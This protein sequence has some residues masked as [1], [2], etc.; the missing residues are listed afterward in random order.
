MGN[1]KDT[2]PD[3]L[4]EDGSVTDLATPLASIIG[5]LAAERLTKYLKLTTVGE[6]LQH[7]PRRYL[8]PKELTPVESLV[9]GEKVSVVARVTSI[10]SRAMR[11]R[12][13][14]ITTVEIWDGTA[15]LSG[16]ME[17]T[18]FYKWRI[19]EELSVGSTA[20]FNGT[21]KA[22][23]GRKSL[24]NP[25][26]SV[27]APDEGLRGDEGIA[28]V[29]GAKMPIPIY[30]VS[31]KLE[32]WE[33]KR[34]AQTVLQ[35]VNLEALPDPLPA[36][37][38]ER[39][40]FGPLAEA[41]RGIHR[42]WD[43][44]DWKRARAH[45]RYAEAL[46]MQT[47]LARRRAIAASQRATARPG[48]PD[49]LLTRFDAS[50]PFDLTT[51]QREVGATIADGVA[52]DRAMNRLLQG[53]VGSGKTVVALRAMLQVIDS[54]GQ[55]ALLAP[56][57]VLAA[58]HYESIRAILG[59]LAEGGMLGG[60]EDGTRVTLLTG[61][62]PTSAKKK[63]LLEAASGDAGIVVGT[64]A[65]L[66]EHVQFFDLGLIVVDEQH[67]FGVEQRDTLR[68]K[69][70]K[71]PHLLVMTA[72]PI[73]RTVAMTVFGDLE[74]SVLRELPAGRAPITTHV[75]GL[76]QHPAWVERIW[77]RT[78]EEVEA[79]HQVYVVCPKIG[80]DYSG[81][82]LAD[83]PD[84]YDAPDEAPAVELTSV[85]A[86][87]DQLAEVPVL[88]GVRIAMLHGRMDPVDKAS[89]MA[90]FA[91]GDVDVLVSTTVIEVGVDVPNATLM[92]VMDADR[93]GISQ[94]H[95]LRGRVGRGGL[96]GTALL[97]T[98]LEPDHPSLE[99]LGVV[100]GTTDGFVLAEEDLRFRKEGDVL[101]ASQSGGK[102]ALQLLRVLDHGEIISRARADSV[103][104]I[105]RDLT[106][107][108]H[109]ELREAIELYLNPEKEEFLERG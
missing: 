92:V 2:L 35:K 15:G 29:D 1:V 32:S 9:V 63:A 11:Q 51:G 66:S 80:D 50:L 53:E 40:G 36:A 34:A 71:P 30:P 86:L 107:T 62:M 43:D 47:A 84:A 81:A 58:Q 101:G 65:L 59:P 6:L 88:A 70:N 97:V 13:G 83:G 17:L 100:A 20:L 38:A 37:V 21:V 67:R 18:F 3:N 5:S 28:G 69:A 108:H 78:R 74:T 60:A 89:T 49:G 79:G 57:E 33:V 85:M 82:A 24:S 90:A 26:F 68:S 91:A 75:V 41:Y 64:H 25:E 39:E 94:L 12:K 22:F 52:S 23:G 87:A 31:G 42:P 77:A 98:A 61:S 55:A 103:D 16:I 102:S 99:R 109:P 104:I 27:L 4:P 72:T 10:S 8:N 7:F 48:K 19:K 105:E 14:T 106:L 96:P 76:V 54:G 56:T 46:V 93:F 73:P 44:R 45:F 95:Q